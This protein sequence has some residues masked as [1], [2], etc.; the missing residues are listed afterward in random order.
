MV[1]Q[2]GEGEDPGFDVL[3]LRQDVAFSVPRAVRIPLAANLAPHAGKM[4]SCG[5][6][7]FRSRNGSPNSA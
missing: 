5:A 6:P 1:L 3:V 4:L 2:A 7:S